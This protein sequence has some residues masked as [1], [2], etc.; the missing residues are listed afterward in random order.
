[1]RAGLAEWVLAKRS[2]IEPTR[3]F[4]LVDAKTMIVLRW[5]DA[6]VIHTQL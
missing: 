1:M 5:H 4:I 2:G 3:T 6:G